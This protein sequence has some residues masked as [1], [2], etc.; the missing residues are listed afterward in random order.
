MLGGSTKAHL[1]F[2]EGCQP[3]GNPYNTVLAQLASLGCVI[4]AHAL[5]LSTRHSPLLLVPIEVPPRSS[6][7]VFDSSHDGSNALHVVHARDAAPDPAGFAWK[8]ADEAE[9]ARQEAQSNAEMAKQK[10][11]EARD[12]AEVAQKKEEEATKNLLNANYNLAKFLEKEASS[13]LESNQKPHGTAFQDTLWLRK[14]WLYS[15]E[16]IRSAIPKD[17][18]MVGEHLLD[19]LELLGEQDLFSERKINSSSGH[20]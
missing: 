10:E 20:F 5:D 12:N 6:F 15:L 13:L 2:G 9:L 19:S 3:L 4:V 11:A 8:S 16:A 7:P 1:G 17:K 18:K 14:A